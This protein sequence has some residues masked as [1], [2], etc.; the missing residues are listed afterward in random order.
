METINSNCTFL[1]HYDVEVNFK[2][3]FHGKI[4]WDNDRKLNEERQIK[5]TKIY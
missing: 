2:E 1:I 3:N 4:G 5:A